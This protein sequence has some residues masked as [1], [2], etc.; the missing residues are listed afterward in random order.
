MTLMEENTENELDDL[1]HPHSS[2]LRLFAE[3]GLPGVLAGVLLA[4]VL[5]VNGWRCVDRTDRKSFLMGPFFALLGLLL[6]SVFDSVLLNVNTAAL[7]GA[8][9]ALCPAYLPC[10]GRGGDRT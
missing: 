2:A 10:S 8:L 7:I 6:V 4:G 9:G 1:A 5:L 3:H